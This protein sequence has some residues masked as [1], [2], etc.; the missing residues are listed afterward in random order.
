MDRCLWRLGNS[1]YFARE[2]E[3]DCR[4]G[5][6]E[7]RDQYLGLWDEHERPDRQILSPN[8]EM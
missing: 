5:E 4:S 8:T 6:V 1:G 3:R 7:T 2:E